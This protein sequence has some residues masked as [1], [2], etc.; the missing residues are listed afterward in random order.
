[1]S[2]QPDRHR[3][4]YTNVVDLPG[5]PGMRDAIKLLR[6]NGIDVLDSFVPDSDATGAPTIRFQGNAWA[7][8]KAFAIAMESGLSVG[9]IQR[10]WGA[11]DGQIEGPWWEI[12]FHTAD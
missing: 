9:R 2:A 8:Y 6:D 5:D 7:G 11:T 12:T 1:M 10:V 3:E 4:A